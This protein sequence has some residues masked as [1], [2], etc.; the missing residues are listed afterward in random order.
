MVTG[1]CYVVARRF[2]MSAYRAQF[3]PQKDQTGARSSVAPIRLKLHPH[4][5]KRYFSCLAM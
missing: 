3:N 2:K 1:T 4:S 5:I